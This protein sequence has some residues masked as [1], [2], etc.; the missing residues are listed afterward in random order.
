M[1][2]GA[3]DGEAVVSMDGC[4]AGCGEG[5]GLRRG[6]GCFWEGTFLMVKGIVMIGRRKSQFADVR[7]PMVISRK[8]II[9]ILL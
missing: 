6:E 3:G 8:R 1:G 2:A 5:E 4:G 7:S 9:N